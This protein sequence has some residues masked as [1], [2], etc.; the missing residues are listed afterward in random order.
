MTETNEEQIGIEKD[1]KNKR[2]ERDRDNINSS[3]NAKNKNG[4]SQME[5]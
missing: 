5:E 2:V 1:L 4:E 3:K